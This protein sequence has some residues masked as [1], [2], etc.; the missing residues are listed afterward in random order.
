MKSVD[1]PG[2]RPVILV[3]LSYFLPGYRAGGPAQ[4]VSNAAQSLCSE[5]DFRIV[6]LDRDYGVNEP[7]KNIRAN[8]WRD[9]GEYSVFYASPGQA[10]YALV[11][12]LFGEV[13]PNLV[14]LNS[15]F[16]RKFSMLPFFALGRGRRVPI[17]LTPR[18]E[19]SPGALGVKAL[20][21]KIFLDVVKASGLYRHVYWHAT[22]KP[23]YE[24][25]R[26]VFQPENDRIFLASNLPERITQYFSTQRTP[27]QAGKLRIILAARISKMKNTLSAIQIVNQLKGD[28]EFDLWGPCED[29][30]YWTSC[31]SEISK[32]PKNIRI[33]YRGGIE[34]DKL[35]GVLQEY[36]VFLMPTLGENFGHSIFEALSAGLPVVISD[37]TPWRNLASAGV[38]ADFPLDNQKAFVERLS[39]YQKM[40]GDQFS[41]IGKTCHEFSVQWVQSNAKLDD[42]RN[43]LVRCISP[44]GKNGGEYKA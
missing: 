8:E 4:S 32:G 19:L 37:R 30:N 3:F 21:K 18:G 36:D 40:D 25:I 10:G 42:Y 28:V 1:K 31:L 7:Y 14:Y 15:L 43:M 41:Q 16:D 34:H 44:A 27:K 39:E 23:E 22:S 17:L 6:C 24:S 38:G 2:K 33:A 12:K 26:R 35:K 5:Y 9:L 29:K 13:R 20:K 11:K